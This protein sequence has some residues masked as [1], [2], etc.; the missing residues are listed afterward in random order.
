MK[1]KSTNNISVE[2]KMSQSHIIGTI[3]KQQLIYGHD[4]NQGKYFPVSVSNGV[5]NVNS[6]G[7][8]WIQ[9]TIVNELEI[10]AGASISSEVVDLQGANSSQLHFWSNN[11]ADEAMVFTVQG[12]YDGTTFYENQTVHTGS[13][14]QEYFT[15]ENF[16]MNFPR[17]FKIMCTESTGAEPTTLDLTLC[18]RK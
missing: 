2:Y 11:S 5:V 4:Q 9:K 16:G 12:S 13:G 15:Q 17:Y 14:L 1:N 7:G 18:I 3:G 10:E 8:E 6:T